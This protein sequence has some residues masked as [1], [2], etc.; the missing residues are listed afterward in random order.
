[1][2]DDRRERKLVAEALGDLPPLVEPDIDRRGGTGRVAT[3]WAT[4]AELKHI[5]AALENPP[6]KAD[7]TAAVAAAI[8]ALSAG[9]KVLRDS[10]VAGHF[11]LDAISLI[12]VLVCIGAAFE[13]VRRYVEVARKT[14][15][16]HDNAIADV[17]RLQQELAQERRAA[18]VR[19]P[20]PV[21]RVSDEKEGSAE[22]DDPETTGKKGAT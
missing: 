10:V 6:P 14:H 13:A 9:I 12:L 1:M 19:V 18:Q 4:E 17:K 16:F 15:P 2:P 11:V 21:Y 3:S 20:T 5:L 7:P 22:P 8:S